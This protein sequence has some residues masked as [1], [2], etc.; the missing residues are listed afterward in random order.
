MRS[1]DIPCR[2]GGEEFIALLKNCQ[3][4]EA[5]AVAER[6]R[7]DVEREDMTD[8]TEGMHITISVGVAEATGANDKDA[9][10]M[11]DQALYRAKN[12]GRNRDCTYE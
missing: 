7:R 6:L 10:M 4:A 3:L 9:V 8:I 2:W 5:V 1:A 12:L 11:A